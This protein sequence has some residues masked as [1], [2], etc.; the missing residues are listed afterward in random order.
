MAIRSEV[1][2]SLSPQ[3]SL[4]LELSDS[5]HLESFYPGKNS[6]VLQIL[7]DF[8]ED[9][10][11][12]AIYLWGEPGSGKSHLLQGVCQKAIER[13]Q[14]VIYVTMKEANSYSEAIL[15]NLEQVSVVCIDDIECI[16]NKPS[17]EEAMFVL[18]N[19]IMNNGG[20]LL[21]AGVHHPKQLGLSLSDLASRLCW[22]QCLK[23]VSLDDQELIEALKLRAKQSG[24]TLPEDVIQFLLRRVRRDMASLTQILSQLNQASIVEQ[25]KLTVPFVKQVLDL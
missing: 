15:E 25:R 3:L 1:F 7:K 19:S 18:Y 17:W 14:S 8:S 24:L 13:C 20:R 6:E 12:R 9:K 4:G 16:A 23:L 22:G 11:E 21:V 2:V 10:R 5:A